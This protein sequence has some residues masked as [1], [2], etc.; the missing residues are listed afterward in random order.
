MDHIRDEMDLLK[1][2]MVLVSREFGEKC[3]VVLHSY[4]DGYNK[5][6]IAIENGQVSG[7][8]VGDCGGVLGLEVLKGTSDGSNQF[9]YV[10]TTKNGKILRSSTGYLYN[11][12]HEP[13]GAMCINYDITDALNVKDFDPATLSGIEAN[14]TLVN[15]V[16][17]LLDQLLEECQKYV[18]KPA[19]EMK[20]EDKMKALRFLD[21][22]G[23]F[24]ITKSGTR[25]CKF[26]NISKFTLYNYLDELRGDRQAKSE[27]AL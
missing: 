27:A 10:T 24:L 9:N 16:T 6:I 21:E 8:K 2:F 25:I 11:D 5:T 15:S 26:L 1:N 19:E 7:R 22:K 17:E 3:E 13:I 18:G 4:E 20:K 14:E 23:A 12:K